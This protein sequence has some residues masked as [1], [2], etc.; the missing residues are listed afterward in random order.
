MQ[1]STCGQRLTFLIIGVPVSSEM[2][3][4]LVQSV[5]GEQGGGIGKED[6]QG[7]RAAEHMTTN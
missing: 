3:E 4:G 6:M 2:G 5:P 7:P 1:T